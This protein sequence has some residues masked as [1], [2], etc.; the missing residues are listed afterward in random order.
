[1]KIQYT[2]GNFLY[3]DKFKN[4][5]ILFKG[6]MLEENGK[7]KKFTKKTYK[8]T[9]TVDLKN[10]L[11]TPIFVNAHLHLGETNFRPLP[12]KMTLLEYLAHT[13]SLNATL[14]E[15][16]QENW[17][18][19]AEKTLSESLSAGT[20]V[21]NTIRG[22][23]VAGEYPIKAYSGFPIMKSKKLGGFI[24]DGLNKYK[25]FCNECQASG[26]TPL[27][28]FHS[29]YSNDESSFELAKECNNFS[30]TFFA[31]HAAEDKETE[32][33]IKQMWGASTIDL[34]DKHNLL[35]KKAIL[36]HCNAVSESEL[37][38]IKRRKASIVLCPIST[39]NLKNEIL[40]VEMLIKKNIN[41][42]IATDGLATGESANLL[43][44]TAYVL[45]KSHNYDKILKSITLNPTKALG[46]KEYIL[47]K[48]SL[49]LF[50]IFECSDGDL[51]TI[52]KKLLNNELRLV[53]IKSCNLEN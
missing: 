24:V 41:F 3:F 39:H 8:S 2:N 37:E 1:M 33:K 32:E 40:D 46:I 29:F 5:F 27:V 4:K 23:D 34:L 31:T 53:E 14:G 17:R 43:A 22:Q 9:K 10:Y 26:I 16:S 48:N 35:N 38:K 7:I 30:N 19:S 25:G 6:N 12:K 47:G 13:E 42:C 15:K 28:F 52:L 50:N 11:V 51:D 44:Q 36:V 45:G 18:N 21:I 20:Y 49:S